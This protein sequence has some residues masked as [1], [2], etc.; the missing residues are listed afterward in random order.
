MRRSIAEYADADSGDLSAHLTNQ[1]VQ[2]K[3][4]KYKEMFEDTTW[5]MDQ[6]N[7]YINE[8]VSRQTC[9]GRA[10]PRP[11]VCPAVQ[12]KRRRLCLLERGPAH[13]HA[14]ERSWQDKHPC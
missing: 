4:P 12:T 11:R 1:A 13:K 8:M 2:K 7:D 14:S 5:G 9:R 6:L 10:C 3:H